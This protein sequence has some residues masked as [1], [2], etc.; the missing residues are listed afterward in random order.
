MNIYLAADFERADEVNEV[1]RLLERLARARVVSRW[2][3]D[4]NAAEVA[5]AA[6]VAAPATEVALVAAARNLEDI[7]AS[8]VFVVLTTG[9]PARGGRH[10]ETGYAC[11]RGKQIVIVGPVEHA[12]QRLATTVISDASQLTDALA[13]AVP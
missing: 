4:P 3:T 12:F 13:R 6:R 5:A 2:H 1:A 10:F 8:D 9:L 11:A 7:D